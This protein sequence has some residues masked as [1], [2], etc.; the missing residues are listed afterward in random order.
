MFSIVNNPGEMA[1]NI[2]TA[3]KDNRPP[4]SMACD[5]FRGSGQPH[6]YAWKS[7]CTK[8][9]QTAP[10]DLHS[11]CDKL[12]RKSDVSE[13]GVGFFDHIGCTMTCLINLFQTVI[14]MP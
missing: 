10:G 8:G 3:D 2:V 1:L 4:E 13:S 5:V 11:S 12:E 7:G 14:M 9:S 6:L